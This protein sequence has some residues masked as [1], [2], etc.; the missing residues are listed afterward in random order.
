MTPLGV[1]PYVGSA[2]DYTYD[3]RSL[4]LMAGT[5]SLDAT[6]ELMD[7]SGTVSRTQASSPSANTLVSV[8]PDGRR[9]LVLDDSGQ[10]CLSTLDVDGTVHWITCGVVSADYAPDGQTIVVLSSSIDVMRDDGSGRRT[11]VAPTNAEELGAP[12]FSFDGERVA[13]V[14][15]QSGPAPPS[16]VNVVDVRTAVVES[17]VVVGSDRQVSSAQ[18]TPDGAVVYVDRAAPNHHDPTAAIRRV[19]VATHAVSTLFTL[20]SP[21]QLESGITLG[22]E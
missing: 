4:A 12:A 2:F 10:A 3:G 16:S 9:L 7:P 18:F 21:N 20:S 13:Y 6:F 8:R 11:L 14:S 22:R 19:D 5:S 17:L 1:T 15:Q